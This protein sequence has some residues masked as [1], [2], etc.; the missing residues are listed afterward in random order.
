VI[1]RVVEPRTT[2]GHVIDQG[3][4]TFLG[5]RYFDLA[6][7]DFAAGASDQ[8]SPLQIREQT[9]QRLR[10]QALLDSQLSG[11]HCTSSMQRPKY[12]EPGQAQ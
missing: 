3:L 6:A 2:H 8:P 5:Q 4:S 11:H 10:L 1:H 7:V 9:G 12:A